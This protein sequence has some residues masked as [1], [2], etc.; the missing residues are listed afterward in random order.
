MDFPCSIIPTTVHTVKQWLKTIWP[1]KERTRGISYLIAG[2]TDPVLVCHA[3]FDA[4]GS[5]VETFAGNWVDLR[6]MWTKRQWLNGKELQRVLDND[7]ERERD[8]H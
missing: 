3:T 7:I 5:R 2:K 6:E 4:L 1:H 8:A